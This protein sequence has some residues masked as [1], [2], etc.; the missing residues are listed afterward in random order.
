MSNAERST[1]VVRTELH[2][3]LGNFQTLAN[4]QFIENRVFEDGPVEEDVVVEDKKKAV[5]P[6]DDV[7]LVVGGNIQL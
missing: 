2:S 5:N 1:A 3:A 6:L 7:G 4:S